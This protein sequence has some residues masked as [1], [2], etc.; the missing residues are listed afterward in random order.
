MERNQRAAAQSL[1]SSP[2][3]RSATAVL[4]PR[5]HRWRAPA[6]ASRARA[7][8]RSHIAALKI[9]PSSPSRW[10]DDGPPRGPCN[11]NGYGQLADTILTDL[12]FSFIAFM[13][14]SDMPAILSFSILSIF[15]ML[16]ILCIFSMSDFD[17]VPVTSTL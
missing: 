5:T 6:T 12:T 4:A 13:S 16:P 8:S 1:N 10:C 15:S 9:E 17:M 7:A 3:P 14:L 2:R 11:A